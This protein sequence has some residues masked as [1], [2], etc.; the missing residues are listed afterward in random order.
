MEKGALH[1]QV[2]PPS[3]HATFLIASGMSPTTDQIRASSASLWSL[4]QSGTLCSH[5]ICHLCRPYVRLSEYEIVENKELL[6]W[7]FKSAK[8]T[9]CDGKG[10]ITPGQ[11]GRFV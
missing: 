2:V 4:S 1:P 10:C 5:P 7:K 3:C 6:Q 9:G 11:L 8:K